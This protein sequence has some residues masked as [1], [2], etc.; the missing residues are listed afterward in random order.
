MAAFLVAF[1]RA[2]YICS[3]V[4]SGKGSVT[5]SEGPF[6]VNCAEEIRVAAC[7]EFGSALGADAAMDVSTR[8]TR[9]NACA[10]CAEEV[11]NSP[12][13][14]APVLLNCTLI[15]VSRTG[16]SIPGMGEALGFINRS[17][18]VTVANHASPDPLTA[19]AFLRQ[20]PAELRV[21]R[22]AIGHGFER[23]GGAESHGGGISETPRLDSRLSDKVTICAAR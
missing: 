1:G 6:T 16:F 14:T 3:S 9:S 23:G 8:A 18:G 20:R 2:E 22:I 5:S 19:V 13:A 10:C 21:R 11:V 7:A 4:C 17:A 15:D 12:A